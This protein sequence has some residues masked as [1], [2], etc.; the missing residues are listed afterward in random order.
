MK[1]VSYNKNISFKIIENNQ[2][3]KWNWWYRIAV[4]EF[5]N[6]EKQFSTSELHNQD[7]LWYDIY[8]KYFKDELN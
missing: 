1:I 2:N 7:K 4:S 3:I 5:A 8:L 6:Q